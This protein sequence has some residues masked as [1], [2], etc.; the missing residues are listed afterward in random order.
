MISKRRPLPRTEGACALVA[1]LRPFLKPPKA[2]VP[3]IFVNQ[4]LER[5]L[6]VSRPLVHPQ[7]PRFVHFV[8]GQV[9]SGATL[10][11]VVDQGEGVKG[12]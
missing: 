5:V 1:G 6:A 7:L 10:L 2:E 12:C 11:F 4:A 8:Q 9:L 3:Q